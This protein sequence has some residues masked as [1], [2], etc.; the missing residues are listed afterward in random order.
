MSILT[1]ALTE[2]FEPLAEH[3]ELIACE[4]KQTKSNVIREALAAYYGF[5]PA[6]PLRVYRKEWC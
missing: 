2:D 3:I 1:V 5:T 6:K 4:T